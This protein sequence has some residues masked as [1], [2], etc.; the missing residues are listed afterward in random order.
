MK[1][2]G[3]D[4]TITRTA[5]VSKRDVQDEG[6]S[7]EVEEATEDDDDPQSAVMVDCAGPSGAM[8]QGLGAVFGIS[9]TSKARKPS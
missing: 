7:A 4:I 9:G 8:R 5:T 2:Q 6:S 3:E 1:Q